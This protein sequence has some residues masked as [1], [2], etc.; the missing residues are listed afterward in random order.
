MLAVRRQLPTETSEVAE[1]LA[2]YS[3][4]GRMAR[5]MEM[6]GKYSPLKL[7]TKKHTYFRHI[8]IVLSG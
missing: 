8:K 1:H 6:S 2:F 7:D 3:D 5:D 4:Y